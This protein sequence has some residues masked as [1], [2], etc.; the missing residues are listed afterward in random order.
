MFFGRR[1]SLPAARIFTKSSD[2]I[3]LGAGYVQYLVS[4]VAC[5]PRSRDRAGMAD[6]SPVAHFTVN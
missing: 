3:Q 1:E 5:S 4:E 6:I 2:G